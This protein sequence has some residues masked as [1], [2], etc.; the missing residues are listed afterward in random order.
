MI[1]KINF[2]KK[3]KEM[4]KKEKYQ[5][6]LFYVVFTVV[7]IVATTAPHIIHNDG[8][9]SAKYAQSVVILIDLIIG[10]ILFK[11]YS[12]KIN[13]V[14]QQKRMF[15]NRLSESYKYI[16]KAHGEVEV[17]DIFFSYLKRLNDGQVNNKNTFK[18]ILAFLIIS[19]VKE[20]KGAFRFLDISSGHTIKEFFFSRDGEQLNINISNAKIITGEMMAVDDSWELVG[21]DFDFGGLKCV[22]VFPKSQNKPSIKLLKLLLNQ[23]HS[24]F[25]ILKS[26][27]AKNDK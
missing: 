24:F 22:L 2:L 12:Q 3:V 18:E 17:L 9:I 4:I 13:K 15:E 16:G 26:K 8:L 5:I 14:N 6:W 11:I 27:E 10:Y 1:Y 21:S 25:V 20:R 23:I 7:L 19:V